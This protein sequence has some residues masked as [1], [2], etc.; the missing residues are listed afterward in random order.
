M[1][2]NL[3]RYYDPK[4]GRF[5]NQDPIGLVGGENLYIFAPNS[6]TWID[7]LGLAKQSGSTG[8]YSV[9]GG[10]HVHAKAAWNNLSNFNFIKD[11][12]FAI[13]NDWMEK[14]GINHDKIT[15]CQKREFKK[16]KNKCNTNADLNTMSEHNRIAKLCLMEGG[17][18]EELAEQLVQ[19]SLEYL[20]RIN[21]TKPSKIP[22][23]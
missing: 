22:W 8:K 3:F 9:V 1:H 15:A 17:A 4:C 11:N 20:N 7:P 10:H 19:K 16:L 5:I 13:G 6:N 21:I 14:Q 12:M 2:Y 23:G 18:T